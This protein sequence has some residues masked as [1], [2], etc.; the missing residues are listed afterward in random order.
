MIKLIILAIIF[1]EA[2]QQMIDR[3][4]LHQMSS[5]P[6]NIKKKKKKKKKKK[7][8]DREPY[9]LFCFVFCFFFFCFI[10]AA[11]C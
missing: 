8:N 7:V 4:C 9:V 10:T 6:I 5:D 11:T 3:C 1:L 2:K